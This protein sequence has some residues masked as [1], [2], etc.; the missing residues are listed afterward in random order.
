MGLARSTFYDG[1]EQTLDDTGIVQQL[2]KVPFA[3]TI[4]R[5]MTTARHQSEQAETITI[6]A[7][8]AGVPML[9]EARRLTDDSMS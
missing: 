5:L 3:R 2:H 1:P 8:E 6:A 9:G 4:A 7:T